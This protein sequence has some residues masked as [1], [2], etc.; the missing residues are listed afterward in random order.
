MS[1]GFHGNA[2]FTEYCNVTLEVYQTILY[3][4]ARAF[5]WLVG[6]KIGSCKAV[7]ELKQL[8]SDGNLTPHIA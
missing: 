6:K 8:E 7:C 3:G 2:S 4:K 1:L 5:C